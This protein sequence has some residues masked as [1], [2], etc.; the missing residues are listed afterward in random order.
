M[1]KAC[2][3]R[4]PQP[5]GLTTRAVHSAANRCL[6]SRLVTVMGI[7]TRIRVLR[8]VALDVSI[9]ICDS[10]LVL[11]LPCFRQLSLTELRL[12]RGL[13]KGCWR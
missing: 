11:F 13:I 4:N 7:S 6:R 3:A 12:D 5:C 1:G 10:S 2:E 9:S 8:R